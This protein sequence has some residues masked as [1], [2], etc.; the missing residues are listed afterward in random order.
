M[1]KIWLAR[2]KSSLN[3]ITP[4]SFNAVAKMRNR[5][6]SILIF[7]FLVQYPNNIQAS[8][9]QMLVNRLELISADAAHNMIVGLALPSWTNSILTLMILSR[10][11]V[12]T[13]IAVLIEPL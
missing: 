11:V 2:K 6:V 13:D 9:P 8:S 1:A 5:W 10:V 4:Q 12:S 3:Q 7:Y